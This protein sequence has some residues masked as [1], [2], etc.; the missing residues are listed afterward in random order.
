LTTNDVIKRSR[1]KSVLIVVVLA[2]VVVGVV[3]LGGLAGASLLRSGA[4]GRLGGQLQ[5]VQTSG[6][7]Y[8]G[9]IVQDDGTWLTLADPAVVTV[10]AA[11]DGSG[12]QVVVRALS[13]EPFG[14]GTQIL[15]SRTQI[16]FVGSVRSDSQLAG[17][18]RQALGR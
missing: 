13:A 9:H 16:E 14:L 12:N 1:A 17:A 4:A 7:N 2:A 15:I 11:A 10:Q 8:V 18:Y 3:A 6:G 5:E